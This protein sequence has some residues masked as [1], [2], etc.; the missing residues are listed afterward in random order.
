MIRSQRN[1][2]VEVRADL[3]LDDELTAEAYIV[4][5][6]AE[7]R[8]GKV[9]KLLYAAYTQFSRTGVVM[10]SLNPIGIWW[11]PTEFYT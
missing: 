10:F 3:I 1:K 9:R 5:F 6:E 8:R 2:I 11:P 4:H 7:M